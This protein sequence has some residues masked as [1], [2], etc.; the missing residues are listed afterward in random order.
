M[1]QFLGIGL[2]VVVSA[3]AGAAAVAVP[4]GWTSLLGA[5]PLL[6]GLY[7]A[8]GAIRSR[9]EQPADDEKPIGSDREG[10]SSMLAVVGVTLANGADNLASTSHCSRQT[11]EPS[12]SMPLSSR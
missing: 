9:G 2:L 10:T 12:G 11:R 8:L 5:I 7:K 3:V 4:P 6:L 1:G